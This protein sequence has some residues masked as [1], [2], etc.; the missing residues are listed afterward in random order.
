MPR[1][2]VLT[3]KVLAAIRSNLGLWFKHVDGDKY[4]VA[5]DNIS[6]QLAKEANF[7]GINASATRY[8]MHRAIESSGVWHVVVDKTE[9][10]GNAFAKRAIWIYT[11]TDF[12]W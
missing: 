6:S 2:P 11:G 1:K 4:V 12:Y 7:K 3:N 10:K 9:E 5:K 8:K